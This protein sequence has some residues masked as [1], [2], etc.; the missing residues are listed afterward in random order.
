MTANRVLVEVPTNASWNGARSH[1]PY[2]EGRK[3]SIAPRW[4]D[5]GP[6]THACYY[7]RLSHCEA[8]PVEQHVV[9]HLGNSAHI[10]HNAKINAEARALR[11]KLTW[12]FKTRWPKFEQR[13]KR[14]AAR[15]LWYKL[16]ARCLD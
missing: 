16:L 3:P 5:N 7:Q 6:R 4:C 12:V 11:F 13:L 15:F 10:R 2:N 14:V 8:P 1:M 9:P